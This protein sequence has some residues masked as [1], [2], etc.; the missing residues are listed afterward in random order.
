MGALEWVPLDFPIPIRFPE[1]R[2]KDTS[3]KRMSSMA[4]EAHSGLLPPPHAM[5]K[6]PLYPHGLLHSMSIGV[7]GQGLHFPP[8][9]FMAGV[10]HRNPNLNS[11][12]QRSPSFSP[13]V[14]GGTQF[15]SSFRL[16]AQEN[17]ISV[18][19]F[20]ELRE[21]QPL[22]LR[23]IKKKRVDENSN[24]LSQNLNSKITETEKQPASPILV[25]PEIRNGR[26][27]SSPVET[28]ERGSPSIPMPSKFSPP[29]SV[30]TSAS[31]PSFPLLYGRQ[32]P[33]SLL[34]PPTSRPHFPFAP[35]IN[36]H[37][38]PP[39]ITRSFSEVLGK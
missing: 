36:R 30:V 19:N 38:H 6:H 27:I 7:A 12:F 24:E 26:K 34:L 1:M 11:H 3:P 39:M 25:A 15:D 21:E 9:L 13:L 4:S 23:I 18:R 37:N 20:K 17:G 16:N 10:S 32:L 2:E 33:P 29:T 35:P 14:R 22:D 8:N 28:M 5:P 31:S